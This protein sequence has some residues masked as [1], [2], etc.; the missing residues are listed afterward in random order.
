MER[1]SLGEEM[2]A[3]DGYTSPDGYSVGPAINQVARPTPVRTLAVLISDFPSIERDVRGP[4]VCY[5]W[6]CP[7]TLLYSKTRR[8]GQAVWL[9][10]RRGRLSALTAC[11]CTYATGAS[12]LNGLYRLAAC[13][14]HAAASLIRRSRIYHNPSYASPYTAISAAIRPR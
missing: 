5:N 6:K 11:P 1:N 2:S 4:T 12:D 8:I 3:T 9:W 7:A 13:S 14:H 10:T